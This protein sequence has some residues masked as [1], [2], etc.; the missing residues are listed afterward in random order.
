MQ[1]SDNN[2]INRS[3]INKLGDVIGIVEKGINESNK[4]IL[5]VGSKLSYND[6]VS[7]FFIGSYIIM[8]NP[9][10]GSEILLRI[11]KVEPVINPPPSIRGANPTYIKVI[12]DPVISRIKEGGTFRFVSLSVIPIIGSLVVYPYIDVI[13]EFLG[14]MGNLLFGRALINGYEVPI[15][16][17]EEALNKGLLIMGQP[18]CGKSLFI[19]KLI[20]ELYSTSH[21]ENI[22]V[23]DRTGE[24]AK[25]L[26]DNGID[27]SVLVPL[28]VMKLG[29]P[30]D[31]DELKN[32]V[33]D[34][35]RML[36]FR[37]KKAKISIIK[38][39]SDGIKF[40]VAFQDGGVGKLSIIPLSIRFRWFIERAIN[41][42]DPEVRYVVITLMISNDKALNTVQSFISAIKDPELIN[43]IGRGPINKAIDLAYSLRDSGFFDAIVNVGKE[44]VELSVFSPMR[45]LKSRVV[46]IDLHELPSS[47]I[48]IYEII[49]I[50]DIIKWFM[51]S[52]DNKVVMVVDNAEGL[53]AIRTYWMR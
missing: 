41:Y 30:I 21:Y 37:K 14:L 36:G 1:R 43:A 9:S 7:K 2:S 19:K 18:G 5:T 32:Y 50:E 38:S 33:V 52:R 28:D 3:E 39:R 11:N 12:G 49:L 8:V 34:K 13:K 20:K 51:S 10:T 31:I 23:F 16:L 24:Y 25:Y 48:G 26:V 15:M 44:D 22:I 6:L 17:N 42:L 4:L 27:A 53:W 47:L 35:L 46:L 45:A 40:N 29:R